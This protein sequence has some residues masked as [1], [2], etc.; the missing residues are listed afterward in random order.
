VSLFYENQQKTTN[1]VFS[2]KYLSFFGI[3]GVEASIIVTKSVTMY[4]RSNAST[5]A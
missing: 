1:N 5:D 4:D 3:Y 2:M